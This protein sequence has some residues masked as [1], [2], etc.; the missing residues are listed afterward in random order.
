MVARKSDAF[1]EGVNGV[2]KSGLRHRREHLAANEVDVSFLVAIGFR[3]QRVRTEKTGADGDRPVAAELPCGRQLPDLGFGIEPVAG[4]DLN[5]RDALADQR[6]EPRQRAGNEFSLASRPGRGNRRNDA[7]ARQSDLFVARALQP[8]FELVRAV[9]AEHQMGMTID[10]SGRD[11]PSR[12]IDPLSRIG[13][14]RKVGTRAREDDATI[15]RCDHALLDHAEVGQILPNG[16]E[17]GIMPN[18][19][20]ALGH[21]AFPRRQKLDGVYVYTYYRAGLLSSRFGKHVH[22]AFRI[23]TASRRVG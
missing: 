12:A 16:G 1:H 3:W 22:S 7:A 18:S 11:P 15:P 14:R 20:K 8:Q 6:V 21:A 10:Q 19:I 2:G 5:G 17:P 23:S 9:S 13:V 4:F